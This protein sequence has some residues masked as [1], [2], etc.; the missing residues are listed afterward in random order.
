MKLLCRI[1]GVDRNV[2]TVRVQPSRKYFRYKDG[3]YN[4]DSE[5]VSILF[6][7]KKP[8]KNAELFYFENNPRPIMSK[9]EAVQMLDLQIVENALTSSAK[10]RSLAFEVIADYLKEPSKILVLFF[11]GIVIVTVIMGVMGRK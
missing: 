11:V 2:K 3:I 7:D 1:L 10:P 9:Q 6:K 4:I 5:C 8:T